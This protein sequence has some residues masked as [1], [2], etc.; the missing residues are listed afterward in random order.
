MTNQSVRALSYYR[1]EWASA[2]GPTM[3]L[4]TC[5]RS[6]CARL[7][8][9][10]ERSIRRDDTVMSL[11]HMV[12]REVSKGIFL[13]IVSETPGEAAS[14]VPSD[15]ATREIDV[16]I[17]PPPRDFEFMDGDAFALVSG[18][19]ICVCTTQM[20]IAAVQFFLRQLFEKAGLNKIAQ[21]FA[22]MR[23][24]DIPKVRKIRK[25]GVKSI[26]LKASLYEA[27]MNYAKRK[28]EV[29][30]LLGVVARH[31]RALAGNERDVTEDALRATLVLT[32]DHRRKHGITL[33][34]KRIENLAVELVKSEHSDDEFTIETNSGGKI[35]ASEIYIR[36]SVRID[37]NGKSVDRNHAWGKLEQFYSELRNTGQLDG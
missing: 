35:T 33:G 6:A 7:S 18:D 13:H 25:E 16:S 2:V 36:S 31:I 22:F 29:Q 4:E 34:T 10:D 1:T 12:T 3:D 8:R 21:F 14:V 5:I 19:D 32:V 27:S 15:K 28:D 11:A 30:G 37:R 24:A 20:H 26:H 9:V 23:A 17:S